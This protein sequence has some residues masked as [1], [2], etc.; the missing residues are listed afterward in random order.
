MNNRISLVPA[1][2]QEDQLGELH[3]P[4]QAVDDIQQ[5]AGSDDRVVQEEAVDRK[6]CKNLGMLKNNVWK[7]KSV[8]IVN[9]LNY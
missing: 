4:Q 2:E 3:G 7:R 8:E 6:W 1:D 5:A 9:F